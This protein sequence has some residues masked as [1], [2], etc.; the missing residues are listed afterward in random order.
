[1]KTSKRHAWVITWERSST[2]VS[3]NMPDTPPGSAL[4]VFPGRT[5][6]S[7]IEGILIG[8]LQAF[9]SEYP[10]DMYGY[11][12]KKAPYNPEWNWNQTACEVGHDPVVKA[13]HV[14]D[15]QL[16]AA[17]NDGAGEFRWTKRPV[18]PRPALS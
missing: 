16:D 14:H 8:M 18:G 12:T 3:A 5:S 9:A 17:A 7:V 15:L 2:P 4:A 1:M 10:V 11:I 6:K 13:H